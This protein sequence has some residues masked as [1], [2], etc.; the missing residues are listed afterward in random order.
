MSTDDQPWRAAAPLPDRRSDGPANRRYQRALRLSQMQRYLHSPLAQ[1]PRKAR[2]V[3]YWQRC[4]ANWQEYL[5]GAIGP[6]W[7]PRPKQ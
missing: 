2:S 4:V 1:N 3:A 7:G 5:D 6:E